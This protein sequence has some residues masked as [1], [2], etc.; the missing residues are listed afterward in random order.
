MIIFP[1]RRNIVSHV[2]AKIVRPILM[3]EAFHSNIYNSSHLY[4]KLV[5]VA[6]LESSKMGCPRVG[7]RE[8]SM[9]R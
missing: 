6:M 9:D 1:P 7:S 3:F 5:P 4:P 8:R 2:I